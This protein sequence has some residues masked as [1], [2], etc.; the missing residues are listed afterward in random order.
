MDIKAQVHNV[1]K[2]HEYFFMVPDY[3][4][5]YVWRVDTE[6]QQFLDD[7]QAE[8]APDAQ[9]ASNYFIGSV[10]LVKNGNQY[11]VIDGQ[12]RLTTITLTMCAMRDIYQAHSAS[13]N[14]RQQ[15]YFKKVG[16]WLS[17]FDVEAD[18]IRPRL[19][20][21]YE[22]SKDFLS[23]LLQGKD[24]ASAEDSASILKMR[25]AYNAIKQWLQEQYLQQDMDTFTSF[26][27][28]FMS[29]IEL[30][31]IESESIS[32]ALKIFETINQRGAGLNAMDLFKNLL[33]RSADA[34]KFAQIKEKWRSMNAHLERAG[35]AD[36]PLRFLRY[37]FTARFHAGILREDQ[38]YQWITSAVGQKALGYHD[39]PVSLATKLEKAAKRYADL[40]VATKQ[41]DAGGNYP[42]VT[43]IGFI[44]KVGSRLHLI[45]L[46]ALDEN[47]PPQALDY[48]AAQIESFFFFSNVIGIRTNVNEPLF[49]LWAGQ[50]R[51][52]KEIADI[53]DA[54]RR[55]ML[56]YLRPKLADFKQKFLAAKMTDFAPLYRTRYVLGRM[57]NT[58]LAQAGMNQQSLKFIDGLQI[59]HI[60]PQT[61]DAHGI[62]PELAPDA[63]SYRAMVDTLGNVTLLE[64]NINQAVNHCNDL[65]GNWFE[66]KQTE[67]AKSALLSTKLLNH[68]FTIGVD[69][70]LNKLK[71]AL[72]FHFLYWN[73]Q[74]ITQ[75]QQ[76]LLELA[77]QT[78][79]F[80]GKRLDALPLTADMQAL[81]E[82]LAT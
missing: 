72:N 52:L 30:V 36:K 31:V 15:Q 47:A 69:T 65:H 33:F 37:L 1:D 70:A 4:R 76:L 5:E 39:N 26:V 42:S 78:W 9:T 25:E 11:E 20:L 40:V 32:S 8:Y 6:V 41:E 58:L 27:R 56:A 12:Q 21:Q 55:T 19:T 77:L 80:N 2:L 22:E 53:E 60:L 24:S 51:G 16:E 10:I 74:T 59:E 66:R 67:Y 34:S 44:N 71:Q 3:Q 38:L 43:R 62:P 75:R 64:S 82:D 7:I 23:N 18:E 49:S 29:S 81:Q 14:A 13:L 35:E 28:Y 61:P 63:E 17:T 45:L 68:T 79:T 46:L 57:E 73:G 54:L 48:L 50:L